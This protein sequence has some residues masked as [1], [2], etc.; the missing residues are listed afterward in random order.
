[1]V[2]PPRGETSNVTTMARRVCLDDDGSARPRPSETGVGR[3]TRR[4]SPLAT[5]VDIV[6]KFL[7]FVR[8]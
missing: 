7:I 4:A 5:F 2:A 6:V 3:A 1:M 8:W